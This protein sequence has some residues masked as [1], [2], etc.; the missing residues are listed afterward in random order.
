MTKTAVAKGDVISLETLLTKF[1]SIL[2][3]RDT[4]GVE[5]VKNIYLNYKKTAISDWAYLAVRRS[6]V[7]SES[8]IT[9]AKG[10]HYRGLNVTKPSCCYG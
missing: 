1:N 5:G 2:A 9:K 7:F 4:T 8:F 3:T 6:K 10:G